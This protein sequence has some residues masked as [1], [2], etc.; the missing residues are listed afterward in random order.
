M[1]KYSN[2]LELPDYDP[3]KHYIGWIDMIE[4]VY[5][6]GDIV[7]YASTAG[8]SSKLTVGMVKRI[9]KLDSNGKPIIKNT[10]DYE[11]NSRG[12]I[13]W[14]T[15]TICPLVD[16][17]NSYG[18]WTN[19]DITISPDKILKLDISIGDIPFEMKVS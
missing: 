15:V 19:R 9:N 1:S 3:D 13:S 7:A 14:A 11:T 16:S 2:T 17:A 5:F 6:P 8:R 18:R 12:E 4:R 10:Y